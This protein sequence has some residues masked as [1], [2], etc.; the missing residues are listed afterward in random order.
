[1]KKIMIVLLLGL[2][3]CF[4]SAASSDEL[5]APFTKVKQ[6]VQ[7]KGI[8]SQENPDLK[9]VKF[10]IKDSEIKE[11]YFLMHIDGNVGILAANSSEFILIG[12]DVKNKV[13][14]QYTYRSERLD[15]YQAT[16]IGFVIFRLLVERG[17]L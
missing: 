11:V 9:F 3:L 12:Y 4:S 6:I 15:Q 2:S 14:F 16:E 8:I 1:M 13:Y 17:L 5:S 7:E 10:S